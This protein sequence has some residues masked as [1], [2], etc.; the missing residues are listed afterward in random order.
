MKL[1]R[2]YTENT[3]QKP[4]EIAKLLKAYGFNSATI[5]YGMGIYKGQIEKSLIIEIA[6]DESGFLSRAQLFPILRGMAYNILDRWAP[7]ESVMIVHPDN[8][9]ELV[10][11]VFNVPMEVEK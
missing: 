9:V 3:G 10:T 6:I 5:L 2:I 11:R 1:Y 4:E 8:F 7:Q